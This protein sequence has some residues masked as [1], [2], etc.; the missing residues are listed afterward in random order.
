MSILLPR[1]FHAQA[2]AS[3]GL[4]YL[5]GN[6]RMTRVLYSYRWKTTS[7]LQ[8]A[9]CPTN[10]AD[11]W[12]ILTNVRMFG[13]SARAGPLASARGRVVSTLSEACF[14]FGSA[15]CVERAQKF[16]LSCA[17]ERSGSACSPWSATAAARPRLVWS[18]QCEVAPQNRA[19]RV[20]IALNSDPCFQT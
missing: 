11:A 14:I 20:R 6:L 16:L 9:K 8:S 18:R 17:D 13:R 2:A 10:L 5:P 7:V 12:S 1:H 15:I 19:N 3:S 4:K